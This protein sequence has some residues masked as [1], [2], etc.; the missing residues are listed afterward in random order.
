MPIQFKKP[1]YTKNFP[2]WELVRAFVDEDIEK[3]PKLLRKIDA[4]DTSNENTERNKEYKDSA[5]LINI[6]KRTHD[7]GIGAVFRKEGEIEL[8]ASIEYLKDD[9]NGAGMNIEQFSKKVVSNTSQTGRGGLLTEFPEIPDD[10]KRTVDN[11]KEKKAFIIEYTAEQIINWTFTHGKLTMVILEEVVEDKVDE[12][13]TKAC[14]QWRELR[15]VDG[16]YWQAV[17]REVN[18]K[19]ELISAHMVT[20]FNGKALT[21]ITFSFVGTINNDHELDPSLFYSIAA[22][23]KGHYRNSADL[24]ENCFVHGQLTLGISTSLDA[25]AW[26]EANPTGVKVGARKGHYLGEGGSFTSVQA[27][28]NQLADKLMERKEQQMLSIGA[29][30]IEPGGNEREVAV[31][32]RVGAETA[33][34]SSLTHNVSDAMS[35]CLLWAE[36]YMNPTVT[37]N[38]Y[39]LNQEFF[40]KNMD[41]QSMMAMIQQFDRGLIAE[42]DV[43]KNNVKSSLVSADRTLEDIKEEVANQAP[44]I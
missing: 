40:P 3:L 28:A 38:I 22:I 2:K 7:G 13:E 30:L 39:I 18:E 32:A 25:D 19:V 20:D 10:F 9:T 31:L 41:P 35:Q 37:E 26:K 14:N 16:V 24:E 8:P 5:V 43:H 42:S 44:G 1:E 15:L 21:E 11:M 29:R 4:S 27:E 12:Y 6:T 23:N 17:H 36:G 34:L 33:T